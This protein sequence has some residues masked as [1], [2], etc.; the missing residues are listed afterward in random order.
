MRNEDGTLK[1]TE[2]ELA[3]TAFRVWRS[4][5]G[6][7]GASFVGKRESLEDYPEAVRD[8]WSR[9]GKQAENLLGAL[10]GQPYERAGY[11][12]M[13]L[14]EGKETRQKSPELWAAMPKLARLAW[15]AVSRHLTMLLNSDEV[16][17]LDEA[18]AMW[19][20]WARERAARREPKRSER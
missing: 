11:H 3:E 18:E 12:C 14:Y 6:E 2:A 15:E 7:G 13:A 1:L 9:V 5:M 10:E 17:G 19:P 8:G 4:I 20:E 16:D